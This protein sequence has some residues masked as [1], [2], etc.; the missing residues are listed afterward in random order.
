MQAQPRMKNRVELKIKTTSNEATA[1]V[2]AFWLCLTNGI[3]DTACGNEV[4]IDLIMN[5][6]IILFS[7]HLALHYYT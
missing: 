6:H 1:I 2:M 5:Y 7:L 4:L 3:P